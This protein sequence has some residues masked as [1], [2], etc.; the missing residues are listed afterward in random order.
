MQ[1]QVLSDEDIN[2]IHGATLKVLGNT[3]VWFKDW[4]L[5]KRLP[6]I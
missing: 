2:R 6:C 5:D 4:T 3:G 1:R